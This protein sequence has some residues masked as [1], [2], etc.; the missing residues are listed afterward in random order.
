MSI[1]DNYTPLQEEE[2]L[3]NYLI[4]SFSFSKANTFA[5]N[6]KV[7]E[8]RYI[9]Y[10]DSKRGA[11][12]VAGGAYHKALEVFFKSLR[13]RETLDIVELEKVAIQ[14]IDD[15]K[16]NEWKIQKTTATVEECVKKATSI[17]VKLIN[18]FFAEIDTYLSEIKE[19][20]LVERKIKRWVTINGVDIPL[21]LVVIPD[22]GIITHEGK[23]VLIDHKSTNKFTDEDELKYTMG[24]QAMSCVLGYEKETGL[25]ID[26]VWFIQNK[27]SKNRDNSEQLKPLKVIMDDGSRRIYECMLYENVKRMIDAVADPNHIYMIND[28]D[29][30]VNKAELY[31]FWVT[32]M[33]AEVEDFNIPEDKKEL[34][35]KR[36]KKI[37]DAS[38]TS[39]SPSVVKNFK[40][41]TEQFIQYD[42]SNK[43]MS[44]EQKIEHVLRT[45]GVIIEVKHT[46]KG[47]SSDTFLI[48][49]SA[50]T[51]ISTIHKYRLDV[52]SALGVS[53]VRIKPSLHVYDG[54]SYVVVESGKKATEVFDWDVTHLDGLKIPLGADNFGYKIE[55]D[56]NNPTTPHMIVCGGTG[57]GKTVFLKSTLEYAKAAGVKDLYIIDPKRID[58]NSYK[59]DEDVEVYNDIEDIET[60]MAC[61]VDEMEYRFKNNIYKETLI[62]FDEFADAYANSRKGNQLKNYE[63][64]VVGE[65]KDGRPKTKREHVSTDKSLEENLQILLQKG[66]S[67]G[68]RIIAATQRAS[69]KVING[70]AKVNFPIQ[71]C[72]KVQKEVDSMVVIDEKGAESL[73]GK[74]DGLINSP[75]YDGVVRFQAYY[76][77]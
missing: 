77:E 50:G 11:S 14:E 46:F 31:D 33:L 26:E 23:R 2:L 37:R 36:Q 38:L 64:V 62:M 1:Y 42:L 74:G 27:Y 10:M 30:F 76:K 8:M 18:N 73:N 39:M 16:A 13:N 9:Y 32:T 45:L 19:I 47:Y 34:M 70:D 54:E 7:F 41:Y 15:I 57:S 61:M 53:N 44:N 68:F 69:S 43:D 12:A 48:R 65:Y 25:N 17:A 4:N 20:F 56:I 58:F 75:E 29:N 60:F 22:L 66:R 6:E 67:A 21:P 72:F 28:N 51:K 63:E 59:N 24:K 35:E 55:W 52:A 40:K 5:T 3:S 49:L 71:I